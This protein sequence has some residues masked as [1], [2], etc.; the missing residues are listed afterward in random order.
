MTKMISC[1]RVY[2]NCLFNSWISHPEIFILKITPA[3][4]LVHFENYKSGSLIC[5]K[6]FNCV[7]YEPPKGAGGWKGLIKE[8]SGMCEWLQL[9]RR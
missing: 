7:K 2:W 6:K 4:F 5:C 8:T 9:R 1:A 3:G